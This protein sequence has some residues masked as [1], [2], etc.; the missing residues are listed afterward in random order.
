MTIHGERWRT[1]KMDQEY[2][3]NG[4]EFQDRAYSPLKIATV[5]AGFNL[6]HV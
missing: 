3:T 4:E 2:A 1:V 5:W 6:V